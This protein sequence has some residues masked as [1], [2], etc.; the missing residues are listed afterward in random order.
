MPVFKKGFNVLK[1]LLQEM[2]NLNLKKKNTNI[3]VEFQLLIQMA[4]NQR[5][6]WG[7]LK[8]FLHD[9]ASTYE[10]SK[11]LNDVLLDELQSLHVKANEN[12][13]Q[14][15][16]IVQDDEVMVLFSKQETIDDAIHYDNVIQ[17][18]CQGTSDDASKEIEPIE[19]NAEEKQHHETVNDQCNN[20]SFVECNESGKENEVQEQQEIIADGSEEDVIEMSSNSDTFSDEINNDDSKI[21]EAL[22]VDIDI[23]QS[24]LDESATKYDSVNNE[25]V[26]DEGE[27]TLE[28]IDPNLVLDNKAVTLDTPDTLQIYDALVEDTIVREEDH[29]TNNPLSSKSKEKKKKQS[30]QNKTVFING[31]K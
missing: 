14:A 30:W 22:I 21:E 3:E 18:E 26:S 11:K 16:E 29:Q 28:S 13:S 7:K 8:L 4:L 25:A 15:Q 20:T 6:S 19:I 10:T 12:E 24:Q 23:G 9:L 1:F 5:V 17:S 2:D 31:E 27:E